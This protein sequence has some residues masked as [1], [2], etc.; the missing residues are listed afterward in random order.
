MKEKIIQLYLSGKL[1]QHGL[2]TACVVHK[3]IDEDKYKELIG[4]DFNDI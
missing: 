3:W 1:S 4:G 2:K